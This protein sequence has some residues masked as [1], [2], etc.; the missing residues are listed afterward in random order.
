MAQPG[1]SAR[2]RNKSKGRP[3]SRRVT[4]IKFHD[5][6]TSFSEMRNLKDRAH[7]EFSSFMTQGNVRNKILE[8]FPY[9]RNKR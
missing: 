4:L 7:I 9:L 2:R 1:A 5:E 6:C 8:T 3:F